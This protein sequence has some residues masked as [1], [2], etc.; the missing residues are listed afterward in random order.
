M[1]IINESDIYIQIFMKCAKTAS[2]KTI[3][4]T[5]KFINKKNN[6]SKHKAPA[7]TPII[8]INPVLKILEASTTP[9]PAL[10]A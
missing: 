5:G 3:M 7:M 8:P 10:F 1:A 2:N 6:A 4:R 9:S